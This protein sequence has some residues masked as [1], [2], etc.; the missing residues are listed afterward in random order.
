MTLPEVQEVRRWQIQP[1]DRLIIRT[2]AFELTPEIAAEL[3][4]RVREVLRIPDEVP[5]AILARNWDVE[6]G[7]G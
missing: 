3:Q 1:G 4:V 5:I 7:S 6:V 2:D